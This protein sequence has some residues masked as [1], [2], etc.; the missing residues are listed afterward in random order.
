MGFDFSSL[1]TDTLLYFLTHSTVFVVIIASIFFVFGLAFGA[2]TW[3]RYKWQMRRLQIE[4]ETVK[5]EVATLKRKLAEQAARIASQAESAAE[6]DQPLHETLA[7]PDPVINSFLSAAAAILPPSTG[8]AAASATHLGATEGDLISID[9]PYSPPQSASTV[10]ESLV[11]ALNPDGTNGTTNHTFEESKTRQVRA[12]DLVDRPGADRDL[13][14]ISGIVADQSATTTAM[15]LRRPESMEGFANGIGDESELPSQPAASDPPNG[16]QPVPASNG[17]SRLISDPHLGLIYASRPS[18][19]DDL[20]H[21]KGVASVIEGKL[22]DFGVFT[23]KQIAL[24]NDENIHEF[25][26]RLSFKDRIRR[27]RWVEQA[28]EL[29]FQKYGER[30]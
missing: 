4:N 5:D 6:N 18:L 24:W 12:R 28:R 20:S 17:D 11:E 2:L 9:L 8:E 14:Q 27:E 21:L 26:E 19:S 13:P 10:A 7:K 1:S 25:S 16:T 3:G 15:A 30:L 23:F 22:N 29:H